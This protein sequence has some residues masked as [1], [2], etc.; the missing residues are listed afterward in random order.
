MNMPENALLLREQLG[1]LSE[2]PKLMKMEI[3]GL[4]N[5]E[6]NISENLIQGLTEYKEEIIKTWPKE[7]REFVFVRAKIL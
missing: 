6:T 7:L 2:V 1:D 4:I 3:L 5:G